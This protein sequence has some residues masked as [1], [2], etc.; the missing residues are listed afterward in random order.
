MIPFTDLKKTGKKLFGDF[1]TWAF[2]EW[3]TLNETFFNGEM[4]PGEIIWGSTPNDRSLGY[5]IAA[6][7]LICLH[8]H[9]MRPIYPTNHLKWKFRHF[10]KRKA[11]DVL[12]HEMIH[13]RIHQ[14]GGWVGETR[15]NN[16]RFVEE[17]NRIAKLLGMDIKARII[18]PG[19]A[20]GKTS[21]PVEP[22]CLTL[23]E[24]IHFPYASRNAN[25][26]YDAL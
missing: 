2:D 17:V 10:N 18:E 5:Y 23:G 12:L 15:H 13:Q 4:I 19:T 7:N 24:L 26:Y 16:E 14:T 22:G 25:Y 8:K 21:R 11:G 20:Q 9:L 3:K 1:G 6:E